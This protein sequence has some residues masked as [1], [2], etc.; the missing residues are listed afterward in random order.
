MKRIACSFLMVLTL[1]ACGTPANTAT[2]PLDSNT[3][4]VTTPAP[5][6]TPIVEGSPEAKAVQ[7]LA[8]QIGAAATTLQ[9]TA[10]EE[11]EWPDPGL[12]CP[13][14]AAMYAQVIT[15]GFMFTFSDGAKTYAVHTDATAE[16]VVLCESGKPTTLVP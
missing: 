8:E 12:G 9:L 10:M 13:D 7:A 3:G 14:P 5:A 1:A 16:N 6:G 4:T 2:T 15:P 11:R